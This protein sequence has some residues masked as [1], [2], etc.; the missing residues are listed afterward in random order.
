MHNIKSQDRVDTFGEVMTPSSLVHEML[1]S[2]PS[3]IWKNPYYKW[4]DNSCGNGNFLVEI[5]QRLLNYHTEDH[6]LKHMIYGVDIQLDNVNETI[7]RLNGGNIVCADALTYDYW[8]IK[9]DV[10]CGNPPY[11]KEKTGKKG[12]VCNPLWTLFTQHIINHVVKDNGF[13]CLVHPPLYRKPEHHIWKL[14]KQY[15][16]EKIRIFSMQ[17]SSKIFNVSTK[18]DYYILQKTHAYKETHII[19]DDNIESFIKINDKPF[20]PNSNFENVYKI[21]SGKTDI[22][23]TCKY[24][25]YT[26]KHMSK[27]KDDIHTYPCIYLVNKKGIQYYWSS[28]NDLGHFGEPKII[29][30]F[31]HYKPILDINGEYGMCEVACGIPVKSQQHA[32]NVMKMLE[33]SDFK[34]ILNSCKWKTVQL[35]YRLFKY[36]NI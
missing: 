19:G 27:E 32:H 9:F 2:L 12:N 29:I 5:K 6:I 7:K 28:R 1:E 20:I 18:V 17:E 35:D 33:S 3:E 15:Q 8:N 36:L 11:N 25:H 22:I 10:V 13:V 16:I 24:H 31:G 21:F 4:I 26:Q 23:Y 30:P 14:L 34:T